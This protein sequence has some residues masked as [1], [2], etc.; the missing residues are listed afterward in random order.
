MKSRIIINKQHYSWIISF[1]CSTGIMASILWLAGLLP[2]GQYCLVTGDTAGTVSIIQDICNGIRNGELCRYSWSQCLGMNQSYYFAYCGMINPFMLLFLLF[3]NADP[4]LLVFISIVIKTG[5]SALA[6]QLFSNRALKIKS[7]YSIIFSIFY[8]LCS[9]QL[10]YNITNFLWMDAL[11]VLPI[12]FLSIYYL[13]RKGNP[14]P[15]CISYTYI[16]CVQFYMGYMIGIASFVFF[17]GSIWL[18]KRNIKTVLYII[19]FVE[20]VLVAIMISAF[21]WAPAA[22]NVLFQ[23]PDD[24]SVFSKLSINILSLYAQ[25]MFS[26]NP[27]SGDVLPSLY[28]GSISVILAPAY[29]FFSKDDVREKILYGIIL[30]FMLL[31]CVFLPFYEVMHAFDFP[32]YWFFRFAFILSFFFCIIALK[33]A[34]S[35]KNI[36]NRYFAILYFANL[37]IFFVDAYFFRDRY[38]KWEYFSLAAAFMLVWAIALLTYKYAQK[39]KLDLIKKCIFM[40]CILLTCIECLCNGYTWRFCKEK[41]VPGSTYDTFENWQK[42]QQVIKNYLQ[43]DDSIFRVDYIDA[44]YNSDAYV[45]YYNLSDYGTAENMNVRNVLSDLGFATSPRIIVPLGA[46]Y[47]TDMLLGV[48]YR[49]ITNRSYLDD[50]HYYENIEFE[51]VPYH[52]NLGYMVN[53]SINTVSFSKD[54]FYNNN[55]LIRKATGISE[56]VYDEISLTL[57]LENNGVNIEHGEKGYIF[58]DDLSSNYPTIEM[59]A[60]SDEKVNNERILYAYFMNDKS[61]I[62]SDSM[63][64]IGANEELIQYGGALSSSYIKE[65]DR[66]DGYSKIDI[67]ANGCIE[68]Y[69]SDI[70]FA[71]LNEDILE[72]AY[73][74]LSKNQMEITEFRKGFVK[75]F[76][77]VSENNKILFTSIPYEKGW[78]LYI[79]GEKKDIMPLVE[80]TFIGIKFDKPGKYDIELKYTTIWLREGIIVSLIGVIL[81]GGMVTKLFGD[82]KE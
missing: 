71:Y 13:A 22:Y 57:F 78:A 73:S 7:F 39:R 81:F 69:V 67:F 14:I 5:L 3:P 23:Y 9:F 80:D 63:R 4:N 11:Y 38:R 30:G 21:V 36:P 76:V 79:D 6:F 26:N 50:T 58:Y 77:N 66:L 64:I 62:S 15:L 18:L 61:V 51:E 12:V 40:G 16:F 75:G 20:A 65:M 74:I 27:M 24:V 31:A 10:A 59:I 17:I 70:R 49:I 52:L 35:L 47:I 48:K 68:Q 37:V 2:G 55:E 19:R 72:K 54:A 41:A 60:K 45:G 53:D 8:A 33:A 25:F 32:D 28:C 29:F 82:R 1:I 34:D 42:K 46:T 44:N 56:D 43:N